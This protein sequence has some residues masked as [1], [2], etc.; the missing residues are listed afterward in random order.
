MGIK[1]GKRYVMVMNIPS[2]Y[3][4]HLF[5]EMHRQLA[6]RGVEFTVHFMNRGHKDRPASWLNPRIDVPHRYWRNVGP[7]QHELNLGLIWKLIWDPPEWL[8]LG[9]PYDTF[10]CIFLAFFCRAKHIVMGMEG[11]TKTPG[12]LD[13]F[14]GWFKRKVISRSEFAPVPG[15]DGARWLDLHR[16]RHGEGRKFPRTVYLPNVIEESRF[17]TRDEYIRM[18]QGEVI[19]RIRIKD[20]CARPDERVCLIPA[21]FDPVKGLKEFFGL[22]TPDLIAGWRIVIMGH[23]PEEGKTRAIIQERGLADRVTIIHSVPYDEMPAHYAAADLMLLPSLQDMNPL[24]VVEAVHAGLPLALSD[25]VGN[26]EEG[27]TESVNGWILPVMD[28][29]AFFLKLSQVFTATFETLRKMGVA[30]KL[31]NSQY[32]NTSRVVSQLLADMGI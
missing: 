15:R 23:G 24:T 17:H 10:T 11:N 21:R 25:R 9:S 16:Q 4:L 32:W 5:K 3:R 6:G 12:K 14:L 8:D 26:V 22:I 29:T 2:P 27:V 19:D 13:G 28:S 30:S 31:Q 7:D 20:F 18:G 1:K